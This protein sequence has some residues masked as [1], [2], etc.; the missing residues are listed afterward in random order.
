[1]SFLKIYCKNSIQAEINEYYGKCKLSNGKNING[2]YELQSEMTFS[3]VDKILKKGECS[4]TPLNESI[5]EHEILIRTF[6][7]VGENYLV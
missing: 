2:K 5:Y 4:L 7:I 6:Q 1:M 3:L